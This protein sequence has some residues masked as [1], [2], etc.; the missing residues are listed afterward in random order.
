MNY[1]TF[2]YAMCRKLN[3]EQVDTAFNIKITF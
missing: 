2:D 3:Y 1:G